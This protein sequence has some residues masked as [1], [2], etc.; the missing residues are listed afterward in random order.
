MVWNHTYLSRYVRL[1]VTEREV[2]EVHP[3]GSGRRALLRLRGR[4]GLGRAERPR[5]GSPGVH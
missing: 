3:C 5:P 4:I 2:C 1:N